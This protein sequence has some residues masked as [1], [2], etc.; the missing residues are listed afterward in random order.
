MVVT[1]SVT[2]Y[3]KREKKNT[4]TRDEGSVGRARVRNHCIEQPGPE[5]K[6][7]KERKR[8]DAGREARPAPIIALTEKI[9]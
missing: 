2:D 9:V 6:A 1:P 4:H 3:I 7:E 5:N 8:R